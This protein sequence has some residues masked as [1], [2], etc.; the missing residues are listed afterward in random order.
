MVLIKSLFSSLL[1][2]S[3]KFVCVALETSTPRIVLLTVYSSHLI[4]KFYPQ[5]EFRKLRL[6]N[7]W[8]VFLKIL[9][10]TMRLSSPHIFSLIF[11][12]ALLAWFNLQTQTKEKRFLYHR[13]SRLRGKFFLFTDPAIFKSIQERQYTFICPLSWHQNFSSY[14]FE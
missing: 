14:G 2:D 5:R 9:Y 7:Y 13:I 11:N 10:T 4:K 8:W 3:S 1:K 6:V 12:I